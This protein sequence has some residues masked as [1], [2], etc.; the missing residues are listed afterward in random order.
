MKHVHPG[1]KKKLV[2]L[3]KG[4][5]LIVDQYEFEFK[6]DGAICRFSYQEGKA[7]FKIPKQ[8]KAGAKQLLGELRQ[9]E[10]R[11]GSLGLNPLDVSKFL[12]RYF[13]A[14]AKVWTALRDMHLE[15]HSRDIPVYEAPPGEELLEVADEQAENATDAITVHVGSR[16]LPSVC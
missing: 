6:L 8:V 2:Q 15:V 16:R 7:A 4:I 14:D 11:V 10:T 9:F 5:T 3:S 12:G 1:V 13:R